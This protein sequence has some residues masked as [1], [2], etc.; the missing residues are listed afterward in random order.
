M[1]NLGVAVMYKKS[2]NYVSG[3]RNVNNKI[4]KPFNNLTVK[5]LAALS[6]LIID[7][8][9][10]RNYPDLITFAFWIRDS[11]IQFIKKNLTIWSLK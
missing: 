8:K 3:V 11:K 7:N 1:L 2:L 6:K 10:N 5:F 9:E 4:N